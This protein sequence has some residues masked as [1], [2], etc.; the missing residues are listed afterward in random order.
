MS[1]FT[2]LP[3]QADENELPYPAILFNQT[4]LTKATVKT[5]I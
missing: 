2:A 5:R 4:Q 3:E 1:F